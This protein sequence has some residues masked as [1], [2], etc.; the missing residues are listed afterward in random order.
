[1]LGILAVL[2]SYCWNKNAIF[3]LI[4][5]SSDLSVSDFEFSAVYHDFVFLAL[6]LLI[7]ESI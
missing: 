4:A 7:S 1:M 3:W 5:I 6:E 2:T